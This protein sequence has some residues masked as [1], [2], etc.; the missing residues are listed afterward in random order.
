MPDSI[1]CPFCNAVIAVLVVDPALGK[2]HCPRC[3][4]S[5]A[6]KRPTGD[7]A[8]QPAQPPITAEVQRHRQARQTDGRRSVRRL[9]VV[10]LA[11]GLLGTGIG[12]CISYLNRDKTPQPLHGN[13]E[14]GKA[15]PPIEM[16]GLRYLPAGTDSVIAVQFQ[17]LLAALPEGQVRDRQA[18]FNWI[19]LPK[20]IVT[21][22]DRVLPIGL[23][24]V[25]QLVLGLKLKDGGLLKQIVVVAHTREAFSIDEI[26]KRLKAKE[27]QEGERT[28]YET[29]GTAKFPLDLHLWA[30]N[31]RVL[32]IAL[33][34]RDI[35]P[36][37]EG[38]EHLA[39]RLREVARNQLAADTYFWAVFDSER[40]ELLGL[41]LLSLSAEQRK[42]FE[43]LN[44]SLSVVRTVTLAVRTDP[45]PSLTVWFEMKTDS[46]AEEFRSYLTERL[47]GEGERAAI[48]GAGNRVM[49]RTPIQSGE[50]RNL[51]QKLIPAVKKKS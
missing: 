3:D 11:L 1:S 27:H 5:F 29:T 34:S 42:A 35:E 4:E 16:P 41:F 24:N 39:P 6:P 19:G 21:T 13:I 26:A 48:G 2:I 10:G 44:I 28:I 50:L 38:V 43:A 49:L 23:D 20:D 9:L 40:W 17:P 32:V 25:D 22:L 12:L 46:T 8:I 47:K 15:V 31:D 37:R 36:A 14:T 45:E 30:P 7:A 51:I 33:E 18:L